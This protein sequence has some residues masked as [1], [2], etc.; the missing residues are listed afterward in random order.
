MLFE[1]P[2]LRTSLED[3]DRGDLPKGLAEIREC[4]RTHGPVGL[5]H[6]G[7]E[8]AGMCLAVPFDPTK[9]PPRP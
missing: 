3:E 4:T 2:G 1:S 8:H 9:P 7:A 6:A 5:G